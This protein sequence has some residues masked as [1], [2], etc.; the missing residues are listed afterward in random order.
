VPI[1]SLSAVL[2]GYYTISCTI[3][4]P[5]NTKHLLETQ[6]NYEEPLKTQA[7]G[8]QRWQKQRPCSS[9]KDLL[10]G[11]ERLSAAVQQWTFLPWDNISSALQR[12]PFCFLF[13]WFGPMLSSRERG[14]A[15]PKCRCSTWQALHG[16]SWPDKSRERNTAI[17]LYSLWFCVLCPRLPDPGW[18]FRLQDEDRWM[19]FHWLINGNLRDYRQIHTC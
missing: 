5:E 7:S 1:N 4:V 14:T 12:G 13:L 11:V 3:S 18:I 16:V 6:N 8:Q 17:Y 15:K 2:R 10:F 19:A 9:F